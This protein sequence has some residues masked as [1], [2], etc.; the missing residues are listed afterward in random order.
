[1]KL[2]KTTEAFLVLS[3]IVF[4]NNNKT[5]Y[6]RLGDSSNNPITEDQSI[7]TNRRVQDSNTDPINAQLFKLQTTFAYWC[8]SSGICD[9]RMFTEVGNRLLLVDSGSSTLSLCNNHPD[10]QYMITAP[11]PV[12]SADGS[13]V[14][15]CLKYGS[16]GSHG[17]YGETYAGA[18]KNF[19]GVDN[20]TIDGI[21]YSLMNQQIGLNGNQCGEPIDGS[22]GLQSSIGGIMGLGHTDTY[23]SKNDMDAASSS[24]TDVNAD[25]CASEECN[26]PT[27]PLVSRTD[28]SFQQIIAAYGINQIAFTWNGVLGKNTGQ[29][30]TD[31]DASENIPDN[32][33]K[34]AIKD[35][36]IG[37]HTIDVAAINVNGVDMQTGEQEYVFD[38]GSPQISLPTDVFNNVVEQGQASIDFIVNTIDGGSSTISIT[39]TKELIDAKVIREGTGQNFFGLNLLRYVDNLLVNFEDRENPYTMHIPREEHIIDLPDN[40]PVG[41][42]A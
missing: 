28:S 37:T 2:F 21:Y 26:C 39:V 32:T 20:Q 11:A 7:I 40:L 15:Q 34:I 35:N 17:W 23:F 22:V 5:C 12:I 19:G 33:P 8:S 10:P 25:T 38:S 31:Q 27:S 4:A 29:L 42:L 9:L 41:D 14:S 16:G 3:Y 13:N 24:W 6:A 30:L 1:M 36:G 18:F